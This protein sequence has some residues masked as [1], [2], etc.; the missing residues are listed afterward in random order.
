MHTEWPLLP[1]HLQ[2]YG[3]NNELLI[4]VLSSIVTMDTIHPFAYS[5][6]KDLQ[7]ILRKKNG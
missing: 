7:Y 2:K 4:L 1:V 6:F 5:P 3:V